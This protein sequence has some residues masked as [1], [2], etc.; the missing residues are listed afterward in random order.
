MKQC[1]KCGSSNIHKEE[2]HDAVS[3]AFE[4]GG[5]AALGKTGDYVCMDCKYTAPSN[6]FYKNKDDS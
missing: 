6:E 4:I 2:W 1:P 3:N 5:S